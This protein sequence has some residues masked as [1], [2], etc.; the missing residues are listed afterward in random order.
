MYKDKRMMQ[1]IEL[2]IWNDSKWK[3]T[4]LK[5][6]QT[7]YISLYNLTNVIALV[8]TDIVLIDSQAKSNAYVS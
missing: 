7:K 6:Y 4:T 8:W 5:M 1:L 2:N 3:K